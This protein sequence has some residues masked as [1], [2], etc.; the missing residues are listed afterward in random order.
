MLSVTLPAGTAAASL[1]GTA[2]YA[3]SLRV[4]K[5]SAAASSLRWVR[6]ASPVDLRS[7]SAAQ[8]NLT[9]P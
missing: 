8:V 4:W 5:R 2:A 3:V 6:A 9:L 1:G 7:A